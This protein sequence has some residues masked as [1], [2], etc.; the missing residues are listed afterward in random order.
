MSIANSPLVKTAIAGEDANWG[1]VVMA[2]GKAGEPADR[3]RLSIWFG[4]TRV[5]HRGAR[6]PGLRRGGGVGL[7][8]ERRKSCCASRSGSARARPGAHLR[9]H[10]GVCR[11]QRRLSVMI[12]MTL[13]RR[14][15][16]LA[17]ARCRWSGL[18]AD[19]GK[20]R[21]VGRA[22]VEVAARFRRRFAW[23]FTNKAA[24]RPPRSTR[25]PPSRAR[26]S[27]LRS[28]SGSPS[29]TSRPIRSIW[30]RPTSPCRSRAA[31]AAGAGRLHREQYRAG[32][33]LGYVAAR[34][35][36]CAR[37]SIRAR[38][39]STACISASPI[40][41]SSSTKLGR[42]RSRTRSVRRS[43]LAAAA[44]VKLGS[45]QE[46]VHPPRTEFRDGSAAA[47]LRRPVARTAV[48]IEV[49]VVEISSEVD[50]TWRIE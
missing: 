44:K 27:T 46:I 33:A 18:R 50:I 45:I 41:K 4:D 31:D 30:R 35:R 14:A 28:N 40:P 13:C 26:S 36:S 42:R 34:H 47:D 38:P 22:T 3:D 8:E 10:Q 37:F 1:R 12:R 21:I 11:D 39:T 7:H 23:G 9:P 16:S 24:L 5:A 19:E 20:M 25:I 6:D 49:G 32:Q 2:V 17:V 48:P 43:L 15:R 29:G